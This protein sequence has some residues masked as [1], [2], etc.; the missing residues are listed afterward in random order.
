MALPPIP[1]WASLVWQAPNIHPV[2]LA[3]HAVV[4]G[5]HPSGRAIGPGPF[6]GGTRVTALQTAP[7]SEVSQRANDSWNSSFGA[8]VA[9]TPIRKPW[10]G[11]RK[12][13]LPYVTGRASRVQVAPQS[14]VW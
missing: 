8:A 4:T 14:D 3:L 1:G 11:S 13:T 7:P 6:A 5:A 9:Y 2:P 10:S 12:V